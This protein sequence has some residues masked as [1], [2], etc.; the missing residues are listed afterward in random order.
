MYRLNVAKLRKKISEHGPAT[1]HAL[2]NQAGINQTTAY[3]IL[4][5]GAQPD[6][7]TAI[8]LS[9]TYDFDLRDVMDEVIDTAEA[10]A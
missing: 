7:I 10:T 2:Q 1:G 8:R 9:V 6:L 5:G 4:R 3:R